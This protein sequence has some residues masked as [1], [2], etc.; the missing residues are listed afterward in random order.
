M[1][2]IRHSPD[3]GD[4]AAINLLEKVKVL[5]VRS[6]CLYLIYHDAFASEA[7]SR[8]VSIKS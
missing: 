3:Q 5:P 6:L 4:G 1:I 8:G 2:D 7:L